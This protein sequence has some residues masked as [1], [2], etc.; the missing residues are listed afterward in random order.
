MSDIIPDTTLQRLLADLDAAQ[1]QLTI[2]E[3]TNHSGPK[4]QQLNDY[5]AAI[6]RKIDDRVHGLLSGLKAQLESQ[7]AAVRKLQQKLAATN[8]PP[9][10]AETWSPLL[11]PGEKPDIRKSGTR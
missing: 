8:P 5:I 10:S 7:K 9:A 11:A 6:N 3:V 2:L 4:V 1:L